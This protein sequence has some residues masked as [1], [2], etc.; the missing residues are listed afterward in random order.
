MQ[1]QSELKKADLQVTDK[2]KKSW[3]Q[4]RKLTFKLIFNR[5]VDVFQT[6][7]L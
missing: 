3:P 7:Q 1:M 5:F 2:D 4:G 6:S